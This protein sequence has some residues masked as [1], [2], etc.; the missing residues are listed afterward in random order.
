MYAPRPVITGLSP[1][2]RRVLTAALVRQYRHRCAD[3][4]RGTMTRLQITRH[5]DEAE[6]AYT[7]LQRL[8]HD[9]TSLPPIPGRTNQKD[10]P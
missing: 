3:L 4:R 7:L 10:T 9:T 1:E 8:H 6:T 5:Q 2:E